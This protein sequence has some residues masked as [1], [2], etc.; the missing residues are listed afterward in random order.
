[1]E[2]NGADAISVGRESGVGAGATRWKGRYV[3]GCRVSVAE[4]SACT[5]NGGGDDALGRRSGE[6]GGDGKGAVN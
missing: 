1:M 2:Q 4:K 3:W 6:D 5:G